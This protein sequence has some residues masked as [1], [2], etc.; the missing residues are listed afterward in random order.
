MIPRNPFTSKIRF[1]VIRAK[2]KKT[3]SKNQS[4]Q[5]FHELQILLD[6]LA[7]EEF[8]ER[9]SRISLLA[10]F[11]SSLMPNW[12]VRLPELLGPFFSLNIWLQ[13]FSNVAFPEG[14][15]LPEK[16]SKNFF[17]KFFAAIIITDIIDRFLILDF[18]LKGFSYLLIIF[19]LF[20]R[21]C[22]LIIF[23]IFFYP[24]WLAKVI[25]LII[26]SILVLLRQFI[27]I[28]ISFFT[29][30]LRKFSIIKVKIFL[31]KCF[32][33]I[34]N[35]IRILQDRP[36]YG[37]FVRIISPIYYLGV[38][39]CSRIYR[40]LILKPLLHEIPFPIWRKTNLLEQRILPKQTG[41]LQI[42]DLDFRTRLIDNID[43]S[44]H[45][46]G[47]LLDRIR[48]KCDYPK[49][50]DL[51]LNFG[52]K[53]KLDLNIPLSALELSNNS[54]LFLSIPVIG[55]MPNE[56]LKGPKKN[57]KS[58][59]NTGDSGLKSKHKSKVDNFEES[60]YIECNE[61]EEPP[62][63]VHRYMVNSPTKLSSIK[64]SKNNND[65][66]NNSPVGG[67]K[68]L[69]D[70][71]SKIPETN[72]PESS[73][74]N[75]RIENEPDADFDNEYYSDQEKFE[76]ENQREDKNNEE[77]KTL[78]KGAQ[79]STSKDASE[80]PKS[81]QTPIF[82]LNSL[83]QSKMSDSE[84]LNVLFIGMQLLMTDLQNRHA[85]ALKSQQQPSKPLET[86]PVNPKS[87]LTKSDQETIAGLT[88]F[89]P[90]KTINKNGHTTSSKSPSKSKAKEEPSDD[91]SSS[92]SSSFD[93]FSSDEDS[94]YNSN[95]ES[96][97]NSSDDNSDDDSTDDSSGD[98]K[99]KKKGS[100]KKHNKKSSSKDIKRRSKNSS[101]I[102]DLPKKSIYTRFNIEKECSY[103]YGDETDQLRFKK[104]IPKTNYQLSSDVPIYKKNDIFEEWWIKFKAAIL[105]SGLCGFIDQIIM[106]FK[107]RMDKPIRE[108]LTDLN[109][110]GR[111]DLETL[112]HVV[113]CNYNRK[114]ITKYHYQK[115]L[116]IIQ[117]SLD[118]TVSSYVMRFTYLLKKAKVQDKEW[119]RD[120][121]KK[122][123]QPFSFFEKVNSKCNAS[124][125]LK[126]VIQ[127][128]YKYEE[129]FKES[130]DY[131]EH[132][133]NIRLQ[134]N[135]NKP[136]EKKKIQNY[137]KQQPKGQHD[138][139]G[140]KLIHAKNQQNND[141]SKKFTKPCGFCGKMHNFHEC[142]D[143]YPFYLPS[144]VKLLLSLNRTPKKR[145]QEPQERL[146][147]DTPWIADLLAKQNNQPSGNSHNQKNNN[148]NNNNSNYNN[149]NNNTDRKANVA[150][151]NGQELTTPI[152]T[153]NPTNTQ[154]NNQQNLKNNNNN[155]SNNNETGGKAQ[156]TFS[157]VPTNP[158]KY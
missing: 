2:Y 111:P 59:K 28:S 100:R 124:T 115:K 129:K 39:I 70:S 64:S 152:A 156:T 117:K 66:N 63:L 122:G 56:K 102:K 133:S 74:A 135:V 29:N 45:T 146:T 126:R 22:K 35:Y 79:H 23:G 68:G 71:P 81:N 51:N 61:D 25:Y 1:P 150:A 94:S 101:L 114:L 32:L 80:I 112:V 12:L 136:D 37:P 106:C 57:L 134:M 48:T 4:S 14:E 38:E 58:K 65:N 41:C 121:F 9:P 103:L 144:E 11:E 49:D 88:A 16:F 128:A 75:N 44:E 85:E 118:E 47:Y 113:I 151:L 109:L 77:E 6:T 62:Q 95:D 147:K 96:S 157:V 55:G 20:D 84:K 110:K 36:C 127:L 78:E 76:Q 158:K 60:D 33:S 125:T 7:K 42:K 119:L 123:L 3:I 27:R 108:F 132:Q 155:N 24:L 137:D 120:T 143:K 82:D 83:N 142:Q 86:K 5:F 130:Q 46:V 54:T 90:Y 97:D 145:P 87:A 141:S 73:Q 140:N 30:P 17:E 43:F 99:H 13:L 98:K 10:E 138:N 72:H 154:S 18:F 15:K 69:A 93:S 31:F 67:K 148:R 149:N 139:K 40:I 52:S 8:A 107:N 105:D 153:Q 91:D 21:F 104:A 26:D 89:S 92:S 131:L 34:L 50:L 53:L 19:F 116:E